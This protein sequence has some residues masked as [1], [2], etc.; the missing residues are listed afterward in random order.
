MHPGACPRELESQNSQSGWDYNKG[1]TWQD[2]ERH[3]EQQNRSSHQGNDDAP[4]SLHWS[5]LPW[6]PGFCYYEVSNEGLG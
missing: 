1:W 2:D 5:N 6:R 4:H 3:A